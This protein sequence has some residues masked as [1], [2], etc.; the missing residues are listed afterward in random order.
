MLIDVRRWRRSSVCWSRSWWSY[1]L[2]TPR[3]GWRWNGA[4]SLWHSIE[5][6][7]SS[8][9]AP[10]SPSSSYRPSSTKF[11]PSNSPTP[12]TILS[13]KPSDAV[14]WR[15]TVGVVRQGTVLPSTA[16]GT[17]SNA[18]FWDKENGLNNPSTS[19]NSWF[20]VLYSTTQWQW[21]D[22]KWLRT[23]GSAYLKTHLAVVFCRLQ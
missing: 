13:T 6:S 23:S 18:G 17:S 15:H 1:K 3:S 8:T 21:S 10:S 14:A 20:S 7:S 22:P 4:W 16:A 11:T 19:P 5:C 9:S 12:S 2:A